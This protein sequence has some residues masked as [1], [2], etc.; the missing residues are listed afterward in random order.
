MAAGPGGHYEGG[1]GAAGGCN[2]RIEVPH[3]GCKIAPIAQDP[4]IPRRE[5][6]GALVL[7][8]RL[9]EVEGAVPNVRLCEVGLS[10]IRRE[11]ERL[12]RIRLRLVHPFTHRRWCRGV[13]SD[14]G[15]GDRSA[16][17]RDRI[18]RIDSAQQRMQSFH[19]PGKAQLHVGRTHAGRKRLRQN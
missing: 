5:R 7:V 6:E 18:V 9:R 3:P 15:K 14:K 4:C 12:A 10:Q 11:G 17:E 19:D 13:P 16:G 1:D 8:V 2:T